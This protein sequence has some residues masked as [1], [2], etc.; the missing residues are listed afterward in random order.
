MEKS[1]MTF[2]ARSYSNGRESYTVRDTSNGSRIVSSSN[3][4]T[5]R[6]EQASPSGWTQRK[7]DQWTILAARMVYDYRSK[8]ETLP[9]SWGRVLK[10]KK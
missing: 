3:G 7:A 4:W 5:V 9:Q 6:V 10:Y 2:P 1:E 8:G